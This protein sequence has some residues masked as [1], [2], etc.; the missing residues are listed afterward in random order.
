[1]FGGAF[2]CISVGTSP[3]QGGLLGGSWPG[4]RGGEGRA[5]GGLFFWWA[6]EQLDNWGIDVVIAMLFVDVINV[7]FGP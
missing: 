4:P 7:M 5:M 1:M 3:S 2:A 6:R